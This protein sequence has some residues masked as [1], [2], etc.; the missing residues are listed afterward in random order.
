MNLYKDCSDLPIYNFDIIYKSQDFNYLVV[1]FDGYNEVSIPKNANE[2]WQ[3]IKKEW[4]ELIDDN[5]V[6]YYHQLMSE[7]VYLQT[8]Y[9]VSGMFLKE[10]FEREMHEETLEVYI[11]ALGEWGYKWNRKAK[12]L[13]EVKRLLQ[14]RKSSENKLGIKLDE[15]KELQKENELAGEESS[16]EKQAVLLEQITGKNNIDIKTTSVKKWLEINNIANEIN[17]ERRKS[18]G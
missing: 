18:N 6:A 15:L 13:V 11:E 3:A 4:A 12:K 14:Q 1:E 9:E 7:V 8:R 17:E 5:T 16:I 10:I 2:R